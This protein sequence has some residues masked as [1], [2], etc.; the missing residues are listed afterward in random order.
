MVKRKVFGKMLAGLLV[1]VILGACATPDSQG[2]LPQSV[3]TLSVSDTAGEAVEGVEIVIRGEMY[4]TDA[5]GVAEI[6]SVDFGS[7]AVGTTAAE[8]HV[9]P[10]TGF[11]D[12]KVDSQAVA[13]EFLAV[14]K[15]MYPEFTY[16]HEIQGSGFAVTGE[17][18]DNVLGVVTA[19]T[20]RGNA[21]WM[22]SPEPDG[23]INSSEGIYVFI[24]NDNPAPSVGDWIVLDS[25]EAEERFGNSQLAYFDEIE[26]LYSDELK[27]RPVILGEGGREIPSEIIS[28]GAID[29]VFNVADEGLDFY[30][31]LENMLVQVDD[32]V[33]ISGFTRFELPVVANKGRN[34]TGMNDR[35]SLVMSESDF[36]PERLYIDTDGAGLDPIRVAKTGDMLLGS[37]IGPIY[38]SFGNYVIVPHPTASADACGPSP[39]VS[40][41]AGDEDTLLVASFNILNYPAQ[42]DGFDMFDEKTMDIAETIVNA[43]NAPD[44]IGFQEMGDDNGA[45][46]DP[47]GIGEGVISADQNYAL[48]IKAIRTIDPSLDY[49]YRQIDPI[50]PA[51]EGLEG[52]W[53]EANIRVGFLF[54]TDRVT[55]IDAGDGGPTDATAISDEGNLTLSP[56]R[57]DP[58]NDAFTGEGLTYLGGSGEGDAIPPS[59]RSL[60][61]Q[62]EFNG[63]SIYVIN[64]HFP[65][66]SGSD[67]LFGMSQPIYNGKEEQRIAV[68]AVINGFVRDILAVDSNA[69]I[70]VMGDLNEF[71]FEEPLEVLKGDEL[72][73]LIE[74]LPASERYSYHFDGNAQVLDHILISSG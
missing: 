10:L 22:Q 34:A 25:A 18:F 4:L 57:I 59:R 54:R 74:T 49:D 47:D 27:I 58:D 29:G 53:P 11:R 72:T 42:D 12:V 16:I 15:S 24:G 1:A 9:F 67:D 32:P 68:A 60:I 14:S 3:V 64:N 26:V 45:T 5:T 37:V 63:D 6:D 40:K 17:R 46:D 33:V 23:D 70:I 71:D 43:L 62:F 51:D 50:G 30:E 21:F 55:F 7:Y 28:D 31:S 65:S 52:G 35:G 39:E 66:K 44:I 38:Y 61:G 2:D 41:L 36:N 19:V 13:L 48:I 20:G 8:Y 56:G 73:N 69:N